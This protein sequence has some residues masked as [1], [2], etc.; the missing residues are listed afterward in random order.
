[1]KKKLLLLTLLLSGTLLTSCSAPSSTQSQPSAS[2]SPAASAASAPA[3]S[4]APA[5]T[6]PADSKVEDSK[7]DESKP[8]E[9]KPEES[10]PEESV[11]P[12]IIHEESAEEGLTEKELADMA[13]AEARLREVLESEAFEEAEDSERREMI[14]P[15]LAELAEAGYIIGAS[16][17][18]TDDGFSYSYSSGVLSGIMLRS[19]SGPR[20]ESFHLNVTDEEKHLIGRKTVSEV[21]L[22]GE[23]ADGAGDLLSNTLFATLKADP[24]HYQLLEYGLSPSSSDSSPT[25]TCLRFWRKGDDSRAIL[26]A[27]EADDADREEYVLM[28]GHRFRIESGSGLPTELEDGPLVETFCDHLMEASLILQTK[29]VTSCDGRRMTFELYKTEQNAIAAYFTDGAFV[30]AEV[31]A[32]SED[33]V[34]E[35]YVLCGLIK[36]DLTLEFKESGLSPTPIATD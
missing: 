32:G 27:S 5:E 35:D 30:K 16:I 8:E 21:L 22:S 1:M 31:Y 6:S 19:W 4:S 28:D 14:S 3:E 2:P 15:V 18:E 29:G 17:L 33:M 25:M 9:S 12:S 20:L 24:V 34:L 26:S 7:P 10:V 23:S 13:K 36:A 11:R